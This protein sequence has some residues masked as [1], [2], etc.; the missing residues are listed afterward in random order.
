MQRAATNHLMPRRAG[1][2]LAVPKALAVALV[3][4]P[5]VGR[6]SD[7]S[8]SG[9]RNGAAASRNK[10][11]KAAAAASAGRVAAIRTQISRALGATRAVV[12]GTT[13]VIAAVA[14][15][16]AVAGTAAVME[17]INACEGTNETSRKP[18]R[19]LPACARAAL[20]GS[21]TNEQRHA[22]GRFHFFVA[23]PWRVVQAV[24]SNTKPR[25]K[26]T[27]A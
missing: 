10:T 1:L 17:S 22:A 8:S 15:D 26:P 5:R 18:A 21:G 16:L 2:M 25:T 11:A 14:V 27:A 13:G 23:W 24:A 6:K 4:L 20:V 19:K 7:P 9:R 12:V 3:A